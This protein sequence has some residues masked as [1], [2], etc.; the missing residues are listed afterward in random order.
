MLNKIVLGDCI[1][2]MRGIDLSQCIIVSDPPFNVGYHYNSYK[3]NKPE[4]EYYKW[5]SDI[6]SKCP[7]VVI[8]YPEQL[9]RL[10]FNMNI[11]PARVISWVYNSNTPKQ[12]RDIAFFG[13]KPDLSK[14]KQDYKNPKDKR[15]QERIMAGKY[16]KLYDWWNVNQVKNISKDKTS[17]PCQMP[18]K[19]MENILS[20]LPADKIILDP[21]MGS[22]TT[23]IAA[24]RTG[25]Q[26]IG[27]EKDPEYHRLATERVEK[28]KLNLFN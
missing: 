1:D 17:H 3:D 21:F 12:H 10:A 19:V 16:A 9:Y 5:L 18:V 14:G 2:V 13:I 11:I 22:G 24:I 4:N 23:A 27:I 26:F 15:I 20:I 28:E 25:R 7:S 8:H 6:F